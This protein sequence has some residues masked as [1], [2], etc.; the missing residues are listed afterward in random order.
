MQRQLMELHPVMYVLL[1]ADLLPAADHHLT[2]D[3]LLD[4]TAGVRF[5]MARK[6]VDPYLAFILETFHLPLLQLNKLLPVLYL[7]PL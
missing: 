6:E 7:L 2:A 5:L 1:M 4:T 3:H